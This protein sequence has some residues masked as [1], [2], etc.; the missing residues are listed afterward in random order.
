MGHILRQIH[1]AA[2]TNRAWALA[3]FSPR[4]SRSARSRVD[5]TD[6]G[7]DVHIVDKA[8]SRSAHTVAR[9]DARTVPGTAAA[10][11]GQEFLGVCPAG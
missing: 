7:L 6:A 4:S 11:Q 8:P 9:L 5:R 2:V 10:S 3:Y 1:G